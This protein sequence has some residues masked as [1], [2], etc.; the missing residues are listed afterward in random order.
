VL[1]FGVNTDIVKNVPQDWA[2]LLKPEYAN[3]VALAGDPRSSTRPSSVYGAGCRPAPSRV[4]KLAEA[5]LKF[6]SDLN[7]SGNFVPVIGKAAQPRAGHDPD[8]HPLGL[9][10]L[11]LAIAIP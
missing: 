8:H 4:P 2:D 6:F 1:S 5:G 10:A 9:P 3:S 7:K 11:A